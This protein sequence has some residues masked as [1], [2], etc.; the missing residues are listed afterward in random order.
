MEMA[1]CE[2]CRDKISEELSKD[3]MMRINAFVEERCDWEQRFEDSQDWDPEDLEQWLGNCVLLK[4]PA[5][6]CKEYQI[7]AVCR[8]GLM[9]IDLLPILI[10]GA[11]SEEM[12][13][14]MSK[15]TRDRLGEMVEDF[16]GMPSEFADGPSSYSPT[17]F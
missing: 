2:D 16:F 9:S 5:S 7:A 1:I 17:V 11:A 3:S 14:L 13:K 12:Q 6:E 15:K 8:G 10:S 4:T